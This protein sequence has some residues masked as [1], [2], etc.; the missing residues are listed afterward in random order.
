MRYLALFLMLVSLC[1][2][3]VGCGGE[4]PAAPASSP[5]IDAGDA[6]DEEAADEPV[7]EEPAAG[8]PAAGEPAAGE[9]AAPAVE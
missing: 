8:E 1:A 7:I 6:G 4:K 9:P 5:V 3:T 2:F